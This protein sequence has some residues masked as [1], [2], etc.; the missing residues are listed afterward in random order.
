MN[1]QVTPYKASAESKREQIEKMFNSVS[2][3]YDLL[4]R[5]ITWGMDKGWRNSVLE[6]IAEKCPVTI[7]DIATGTADMA[8]LLSKTNAKYILAVDISQGMLAIANEKIQRLN[9][10]GQIHTEIQDA[11]NL[12]IPDNFFDVA[13]VTYGIRNFENV[14]KGL[15]EILRVIKPGGIMVILE[16]SIPDNP[17]L[18]FGYLLYTKRIMPKIASLF[19]KDK[20][21]YTY[22]SESAIKFPYG[23]EFAKTLEKTGFKNV[24]S[25][26]Q[27]CGISTIYCAEK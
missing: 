11:E 2:G 10:Q 22:L 5:I 8:I 27:M 26:P 24:K 14:E 15:A 1:A 3:N 20:S 9:L 25:I 6:L 17:L 4:N 21:A 12:A 23:R 18:K 7:L 16:T 13:T 19:S